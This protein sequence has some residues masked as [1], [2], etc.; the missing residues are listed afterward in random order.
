MAPGKITSGELDTNIGGAL[1]SQVAITNTSTY[2]VD[3]KGTRHR[4]LITSAEPLILFSTWF[5]RAAL[6]FSRRILLPSWRAI[7]SN[8]H[9]S[10]HGVRMHSPQYCVP[11]FG[12]NSAGAFSRD[13]GTFAADGSGTITAGS[14]LLDQ[15]SVARYFQAGALWRNTLS[16]FLASRHNHNPQ[17]FFS[18]V[19][20]LCGEMQCS[21]ERQLRLFAHGLLTQAQGGH[22]TQLSLMA[23]M[24][25]SGRENAFKTRRKTFVGQLSANDG[26]C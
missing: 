16:M 25:W 8:N 13:V 26:E 3:S 12:T 6:K 1:T 15:N 18:A 10:R 19:H 23:A 5:R 24:R 14:G 20:D 4:D 17:P 21:R 2:S 7:L 22:S 9:P 11:D